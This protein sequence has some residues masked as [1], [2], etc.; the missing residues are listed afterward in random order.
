MEFSI[1]KKALEAFERV[2]DGRMLTS[3]A[4]TETWL[5]AADFEVVSIEGRS[6]LATPGAALAKAI[7]AAE[8]AETRL[9][10]RNCL[11]VGDL[12]L[13]GAQLEKW[14]DFRHCEFWGSLN[15]KHAALR[16]LYLRACRFRTID[17]G[18]DRA[19]A[20]KTDAT[21]SNKFQ[22]AQNQ[23]AFDGLREDARDENGDAFN[24]RVSGVRAPG[25]TLS[26][27]LRFGRG[28]VAD[29]ID[30]RAAEIRGRRHFR[31]ERDQSGGANAG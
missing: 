19:D 30:L 15:L 3:A 7:K 20:D 17:F 4:T 18:E 2:F 12:D 31:M 8:Q 5:N 21:P 11:I 1:I 27:G 6:Y 24:R 9:R 26:S 16:S 23:A 29:F 25:L 13:Q 10:I 28:C 22:L 14:L